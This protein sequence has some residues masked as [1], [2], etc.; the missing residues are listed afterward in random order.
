MAS[1]RLRRQSL[2]VR[3]RKGLKVTDAGVWILFRMGSRY[4]YVFE[5]CRCVFGFSALALYGHYG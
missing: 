3:D 2:C 1:T 5:I 4:P